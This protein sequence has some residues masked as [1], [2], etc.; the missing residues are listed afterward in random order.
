[1]LIRNSSAKV[2]LH[3]NRINENH[4]GRIC[5]AFTGNAFAQYVPEIVHVKP[6]VC[7]MSGWSFQY[8]IGT[9]VETMVS[10]WVIQERD[11]PHLFFHTLWFSLL[12]MHKSVSPS[13]GN[14]DGIVL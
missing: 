14:S 12:S 8:T 1:M 10:L 7:N 3:L 5:T 4:H 9:D 11:S 13:K 2:Y 6:E